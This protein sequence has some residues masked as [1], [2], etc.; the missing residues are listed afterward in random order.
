[1]DVIAV[2]NSRMENSQLVDVLLRI[3]DFIDRVILRERL[4]TDAE[5]IGLIR[6]LLEAGF[7]ENKIIV[8]GRPD[9]ALLTG[10][11]RVQLPGH[12]LP[13]GLL[14]YSFP[15]L[16]FGRSVH[17]VE[18]AVMAY[19][20][21]ADWLLYGHVFESPSKKGLPPRGTEELFKMAQTIPLPIYA[22]GGIR[23]CHVIPLQQGGV[24]GIALM[25]AV[26]NSGTPEQSLATYKGELIR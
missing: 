10:I 12:G 20:A 24:S 22:I 23:P 5:V 26:F 6:L 13:L 8:H 14:R 17:S 2:T 1:M 7:D 3:G 19:E 15:S 25:S 16:S 18:E 9:I 4:K 21:G 11:H